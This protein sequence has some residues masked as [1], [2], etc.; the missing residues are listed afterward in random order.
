MLD[1]VLGQI[2]AVCC[3]AILVFALL[4]G[5]EPERIGA[6]AFAIGWL[7]SV[8]LQD[9]G[10]LFSI[11]WGL[12]ALDVLFLLV[13][14]ALALRYRRAWTIAACGFQGLIVLSH[15]MVSIDVRPAMTA[16]YTVINM[17]SYGVLLALGVGTFW[18]WQ[19][20]RAAGLE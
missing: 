11:Q 6:G 9:D 16:F 4:K 3:M 8:T 1:T 19:E 17:A 7:A 14:V 18:A 13:F 5:D 10:K 2:L 12:F 20:R 15:I